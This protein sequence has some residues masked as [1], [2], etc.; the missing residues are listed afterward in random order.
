MLLSLNLSSVTKREYNYL[1]ADPVHVKQQLVFQMTDLEEMPVL[2]SLPLR[3]KFE[4]PY[5]TVGTSVPLSCP[6]F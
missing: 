6:L 5:L 3:R 4:L 2:F 1:R